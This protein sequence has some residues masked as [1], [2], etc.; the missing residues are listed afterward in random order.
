ME[1][2]VTR[3]ELMK[4]RWGPVALLCSMNFAAPPFFPP[5]YRYSQ[6]L[7]LLPFSLVLFSSQLMVGGIA[8]QTL[9]F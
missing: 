8:P 7:G 4:Q 6:I 5:C 2:V 3:K 9:F 1:V